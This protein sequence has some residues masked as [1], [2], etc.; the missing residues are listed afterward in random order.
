M[1]TVARTLASVIVSAMVVLQTATLPAQQSPQTTEPRPLAR[2]DHVRLF[3]SAS[4]SAPIFGRLRS[5]GNDSIGVVPDE[6]STVRVLF[7][8]SDVARIEVER[9]E[10]MRDHVVTFMAGLGALSGASVAAYQCFSNRPQCAADNHAAAEA[11]ENGDPY[12]DMSLL[13]IAGGGLAGALIGYIVAPPPHWEVVA[14]PT[15][16]ASLDGTG[17]WGLSLGV[18]YALRTR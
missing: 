16:T 1:Q 9:D 13:M 11:A 18:R 14:F 7:A 17:H 2:G 3:Q 5:I 8:R 4:D 6:D 15:R 10:H 12:V